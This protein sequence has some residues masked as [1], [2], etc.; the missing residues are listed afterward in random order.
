MCAIRFEKQKVDDVYLYL[1]L[2]DKI[3]YVM[4]LKFAAFL[5]EKMA[6]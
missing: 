6:L 1:K 2:I 5:M 3:D 4:L